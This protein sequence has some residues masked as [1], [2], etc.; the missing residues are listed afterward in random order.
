[1]YTSGSTGEMPGRSARP[2]SP[3]RA[4]CLPP[5]DALFVPAPFLPP[6]LAGKP[7][8]VVMRH[9]HLVAGVGGMAQNVTL[10]DSREMY[11]SYLPLAH[12]LALQCEAAMLG[13]GATLCYTDPRELPRALP[14]FSPT[15]FAGVP[16]VWEMLKAGLE[17]KLAKGPA[18]LRII[19]EV[20]LDWKISRLKAGGA[21]TRLRPLLRRHL[22]EGVRPVE[23]PVRRLRGRAH[24]GLPTALLPLRLQQPHRPGLRADGDLRGGVFPIYTRPVSGRPPP[25]PGSSLA[26]HAVLCGRRARSSF[27]HVPF[28]CRRAGVVGPPVPCVELALQSEPEI[29]DSAGLPYL[30]TD[31]TGSGGEAVLGRGEI[32]LRG[33]CISQGYYQMPDKT[34]EDYDAE[35]SR[36]HNCSAIACCVGRTAALTPRVALSLPSPQGFFHTGD[37]GQLTADGCVQIVDRKK[38]L[39]KLKGGEYVALEAMETAFLASPYGSALMVLANGDLDWPLAVAC[40]GKGLAARGALEE[41]ARGAGVAAEPFDALIADPRARAEVVRSFVAAGREAGLSKL[42]LRL[43]DVALVDD[44]WSPGHG[45]TASMKLDRREVAKIHAKEVQEMYKRNGVRI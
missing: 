9:S 3:R 27:R 41:W 44:L 16:K 29:T 15:V 35:V 10:R 40:V 33:P 45:M 39:I 38:N 26:Q 43:R 19:F 11:V 18:P 28:R 12:I 17:G 37:I 24:V 21:H 36:R 2:A 30:H 25:S 32:C 7:K 6:P 13:C 14:R 20:L 22:Q 34:K 8:G 4:A 1:M 23:S 5:T 31:T 42:E